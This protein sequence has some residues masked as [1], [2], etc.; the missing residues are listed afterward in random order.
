MYTDN[1]K[2]LYENGI[3]ICPVADWNEYELTGE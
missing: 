3:T 2:M 1:A